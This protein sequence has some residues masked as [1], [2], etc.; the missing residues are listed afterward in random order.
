MGNLF[1]RK[2]VARLFSNEV[3]ALVQLQA[4]GGDLELNLEEC[5]EGAGALTVENNQTLRDCRPNREGEGEITE[6]MLEEME[7]DAMSQLRENPE[8]ATTYFMCQGNPNTYSFC[9]VDIDL[10]LGAPCAEGEVA[11]TQIV[12]FPDGLPED[13]SCTVTSFTRSGMDACDGD[14][15][16]IPNRRIKG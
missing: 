1:Y 2:P 10:A 4:T 7:A 8:R 16:F 14:G 3:L 9:I 12:S 6:A 11:T 13:R 15:D 5:R